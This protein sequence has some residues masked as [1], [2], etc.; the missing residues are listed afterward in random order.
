MFNPSS[1]SAAIGKQIR[2]TI[3]QSAKVSTLRNN[4]PQLDEN[5]CLDI[6]KYADFSLSTLKTEILTSQTGFSRRQSELTLLSL[7]SVRLC[8]SQRTARILSAYVDDKVYSVELAGA[9]S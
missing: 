2:A 8:F 5:A 1:P 3:C 9:V 6:I 7:Q 4:S